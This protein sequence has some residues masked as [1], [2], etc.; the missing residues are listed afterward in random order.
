MVKKRILWWVISVILLGFIFLSSGCKTQ[1][2][3]ATLSPQV[4]DQR[5]ELINY[6]VFLGTINSVEQDFPSRYYSCNEADG[7]MYDIYGAAITN[8]DASQVSCDPDPRTAIDFLQNGRPLYD[9]VPTA[10]G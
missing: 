4:D 10:S 1:Q 8:D 9:V 6:P 2:I 5:Y 3:D 7:F